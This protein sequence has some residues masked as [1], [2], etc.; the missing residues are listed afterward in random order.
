MLVTTTQHPDGLRLASD[1]SVVL[2]RCGR[3]KVNIAQS[4]V[5]QLIKKQSIKLHWFFAQL[6]SSLQN[7]RMARNERTA[8]QLE[9][10]ASQ[11]LDTSNSLK[12]IAS[13]IRDGGMPA[14]LVHAT[15]V[16]NTHIPA[17]ID[18]VDKLKID[19]RS[20]LR[21]YL[22]GIQSNAERSKQHHVRQ[23]LAAAKK[24]PKKKTGQ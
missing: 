3:E 23:K 24:A 21:A 14:A 18:W 19:V 6:Q 5:K 10:I 13:S 7:S 16:E 15:L 12:D 9:S 8:E 22:A 4:F 2:L 17:V 11:L 20:Q 1:C